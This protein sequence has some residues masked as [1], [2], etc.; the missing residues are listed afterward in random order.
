MDVKLGTKNLLIVVLLL[1]AVL[2]YYIICFYALPFAD[3]F[4]FGWTSTQNIPF[5]QKFLNQ[6]LKWNGRYTS[7]VLVNLHPIATGKLILYQLSLCVS[8]L[9]MSA[10]L[11]V[12]IHQLIEEKRTSIIASLFITLFYVSYLPNLTEGVYWY[13]GVVNYHL[14]ALILFLQLSLLN[15]LLRIGKRQVLLE[16]FSCILVIISV[17]FNEIGAFLI[18]IGYLFLVLFYPKPK[19]SKR[20]LTIHFIVALTAAA[21]VF[22]SPGNQI[23][24]IEFSERYRFFHSVFYA[25][26]Q[27]VRF[28]GIWTLNYPFVALS[29]ITIAHGERFSF[30]K[31]ITYQVPLIFLLLSVFIA[32]FLPYFAT[33]ILGQHR[34]LNY[35]LPYFLIL[36][37]ISLLSLSQHFKWYERMNFFKK[38]FPFH[39]ILISTIIVLT[40]TKGLNP[41]RDVIT[42]QLGLYKS[43]FTDRQ[44]KIIRNGE[45]SI[46]PLLNKVS[47]FNIVDAK[48]DTSFFADKCMKKFYAET[49]IELK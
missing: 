17:G 3:D 5:I 46:L 30:S 24:T 19:D 48:G 26:L 1:A 22:F 38:K 2:P 16:T 23:R 11:Y 27:S 29:L 4:C 44:A 14:G 15:C 20:I 21:F 8:L 9:A 42:N 49:K 10:I 18:P 13:I 34:T 31:K 12:F 40:L 37:T 33:G 36:W 35:V 45:S 43:E 47:T 7:D 25:T 28:I 32:S 39:A 6:Y 41:V